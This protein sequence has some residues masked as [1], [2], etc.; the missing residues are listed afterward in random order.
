M[1]LMQEEVGPVLFPEKEVI[2]EVRASLI[3]QFRDR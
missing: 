1:I 2:D 3:R